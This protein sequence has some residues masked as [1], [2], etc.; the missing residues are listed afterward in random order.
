MDN[1]S[2]LLN[3]Y[4]TLYPQS[5]DET[6]KRIT[7]LPDKLLEENKVTLNQHF[8]TIIQTL[9]SKDA[10]EILVRSSPKDIQKM[11]EKM[12][13]GQATAVTDNRGGDSGAP[14]PV[15]KFCQVILT[16]EN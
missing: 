16:K 5:S 13:G 9:E 1:G 12:T 10:N 2:F 11:K 4:N 6:Q 14:G 3:L 15:V 8:S 7:I